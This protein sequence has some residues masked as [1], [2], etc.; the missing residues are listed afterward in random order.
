MRMSLEC[1]QFSGDAVALEADAFRLRDAPVGNATVLVRPCCWL[2]SVGEAGPHCCR[3][4]PAAHLEGAWPGWRA[5]TFLR[6]ASAAC[7]RRGLACLPAFLCAQYLSLA[8]AA[9][10]C[11]L[12]DIEWTTVPLPQQ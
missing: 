3:R 11:A 8:P 9:A 4:S 5:S 1:S 6:H 7:Q 12:Q 2:F 10:P